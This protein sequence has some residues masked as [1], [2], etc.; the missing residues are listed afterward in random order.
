[1]IATCVRRKD[2][3]WFNIALSGIAPSLFTSLRPCLPPFPVFSHKV[4]S[5]PGGITS[6]KLFELCTLPQ[7]SFSIFVKN[8]ETYFSWVST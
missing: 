1:M 2:E 5:G 7:V 8:L 4:G 6:G 3:A